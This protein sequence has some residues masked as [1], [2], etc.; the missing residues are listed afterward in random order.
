MVQTNPDRWMYRWT[1][2]CTHPLIHAHTPK[3]GS[4]DY[5]S[6]IPGGLDKK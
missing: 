3:S 4:G 1:D 2:V 5:V 6:F